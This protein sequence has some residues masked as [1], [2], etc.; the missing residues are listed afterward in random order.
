M[1]EYKSVDVAF[2]D[3]V[4]STMLHQLYRVF[5]KDLTHFNIK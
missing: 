2:A 3:D 5:D 1:F 4:M